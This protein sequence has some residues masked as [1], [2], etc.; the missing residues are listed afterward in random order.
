MGFR[1]M[2]ENGGGDLYIW[3]L[4]RG[5]SKGWE[6]YKRNRDGRNLH[7]GFFMGW[8]IPLRMRLMTASFDLV[9]GYGFVFRCIAAGRGVLVSCYIAFLRVGGLVTPYI[10]FGSVLPN[11]RR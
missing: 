3:A 6:C 8:D 11:L 1:V 4:W 5:V 9:Y 7:I 2:Y 10:A